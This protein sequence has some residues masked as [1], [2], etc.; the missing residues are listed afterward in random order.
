MAVKVDTRIIWGIAIAIVV[1]AVLLY[2]VGNSIGKKVPPPTAALPDDNNPGTV[3]QPLSVAEQAMIDGL[4]SRIFDDV[5]GIQWYNHD[6]DLYQECLNLTSR[7]TTA[8]YNTFNDKYFK[9]HNETLTQILGNEW[10]PFGERKIFA[11]RDKL[12]SMGLK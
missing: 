4:A 8:L 11:F 5:D 2:F 12:L 1:L 3:G 10:E 6:N 7:L 9:E